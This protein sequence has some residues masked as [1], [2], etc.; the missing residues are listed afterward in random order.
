MLSPGKQIQTQLYQCTMHL[1]R[2]T[3]KSF[4]ELEA[5]LNLLNG[6]EKLKTNAKKAIKGT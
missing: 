1:K 3:F 4:V 5:T 2:C 6:I